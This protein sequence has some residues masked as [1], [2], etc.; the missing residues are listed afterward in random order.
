MKINIKVRARNLMFWVSVVIAIFTPVLAYMGL[1]LQDITTWAKLWEIVAQAFQ[2][3]YVVVLIL[4][5]V[6]N[7]I[8]DPTTKGLGDSSRALEYTVPGGDKEE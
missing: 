6:Y 8:I 4:V 5:S 3:P 7:A 2:N 1:T